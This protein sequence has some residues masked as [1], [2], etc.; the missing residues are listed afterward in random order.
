MTAEAA[1]S[2]AATALAP[3]GTVLAGM[4]VVCPAEGGVFSPPRLVPTGP[5]ELS[6]AAHVLHY[7]SAVFEGL[8]AHRGHD[9][10]VRLF[11]AAR[12]VERLRQS[13]TMACLPVPDA[14]LLHQAVHRVVSGNLDEVP[15]APG[16]L[17]LRPVLIG[18]E[19]NVGAAA[20]PSRDA[21]LYIVASPVGDYFSGGGRPLRLLVETTLPR[22]A[23]QF[24]QVKAGANYVTALGV[25]ERARADHGADQ[26]LFAPGGDVQETG[27]ANLLLL[28]EQRVVTKALDGS[29][30]HGVTRDSL[31]VLAADLGLVV[32]ERDISLDELVSWA[33]GGGEAALAGTAAVLA[34]V[35]TLV[36][37]GDEILVGDGTV[38]PVT[39]RL[40]EQLLA[41]QRAEVPDRHGWTEPVARG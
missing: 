40:R 33:R 34:G 30:L 39:G 15:R 20:S 11:R 17:Y 13:A 3:F 26:V 37:D 8:K 21:L 22:T 2:P 27:A 28:D 24:G 16:S 1:G 36:V 19:P 25:T 10:V 31:L 29:F 23:P 5:L 32:E 14:A 6:P 9:G 18:T 35:G 4:M 38:G 7:G 12:H 41:I